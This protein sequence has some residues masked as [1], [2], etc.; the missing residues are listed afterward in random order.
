MRPK[1]GGMT[2]QPTKTQRLARERF[3][4]HFALKSVDFDR[5]VA[6]YIRKE[7]PDAWHMLE[8]DID[9]EEPREKVTLYLDRS[10][11]RVFRAMGKGYHRRINHLLATWVQM[12]A[13]ELLERDDR[14]NKRINKDLGLDE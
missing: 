4:Y 13:G 12:K 7:I 3:L 11:V 14:L 9:V 2:K 10:V 8:A 5:H 1:L 6:D